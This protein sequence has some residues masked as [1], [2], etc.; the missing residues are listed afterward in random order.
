MMNLFKLTKSTVVKTMAINYNNFLKS[1]NDDDVLDLFD[2]LLKSK[3]LKCALEDSFGEPIQRRLA[4]HLEYKGI[5]KVNDEDNRK[6]WFKNGAKCRVLKAGAS[7]WKEG[8]LKININIEFITD[9][10]E[11]REYQ[12]PLDE[13]RQ[14]IQ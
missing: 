11:T 6:S 10:T 5:K 1:L 4:K 13:F 2:Q 14:Q 9:E 7:G 8:W 3:D 12:S